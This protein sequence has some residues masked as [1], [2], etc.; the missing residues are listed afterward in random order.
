MRF[1]KCW[2]PSILFSSSMTWQTSSFKKK[3]LTS[4]LRPEVVHSARGGWNKGAHFKL[5]CPWVETFQCGL[6]HPAAGSYLKTGADDQRK[7]GVNER[8]SESLQSWTSADGGKGTAAS[9]LLFESLAS[10]RPRTHWPSHI[11]PLLN[12]C[13]RKKKNHRRLQL[14]L[15]KLPWPWSH[16]HNPFRVAL[17]KKNN[18]TAPSRQL[19]SYCKSFTLHFRGGNVCVCLRQPSFSFMYSTGIKQ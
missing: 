6:I 3:W 17:F 2:L 15:V 9:H 12:Q 11:R 18:I 14:H 16:F 10:L 7:Q 13:V 4:L 1:F 8:S 5:Y 19:V